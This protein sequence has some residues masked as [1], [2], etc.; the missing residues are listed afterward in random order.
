MP[1][2]SCGERGLLAAHVTAGPSFGGEHDAI[3]VAGALRRG[4][5]PPA[6]TRRSWDRVPASSGR[7]PIWVMAGSPRSTMP[8]RRWRSAAAR[9]WCRACLRATRASATAACL[10]TARRCSSCCSARC[11]CRCPRARTGRPA[12]TTRPS[13]PSISRAML[14]PGCPHDHGPHA[15]GGRAVLQGG[16]RGRRCT[17]KGDQWHLSA[18]AQRPCGEGRIAEVR[19]ERW[20]MEDGEEVEREVVGHPGAVG[21]VAHDGEQLYL[22]KQPREPVGD[23]GLLELPA[24]KLDD[25]CGGRARHRQARAGRGDRQGRAQ[26]AAPHNFLLVAGFLRRGNPR[27][28]GHRPLRRERGD[29]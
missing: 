9:L 19:L 20:R 4:L 3:T 22:V 23:P 26:L 24:G 8:T 17:G 13:S 21:I 16:A 5:R 18:W 15:G 10:T 6:G 2:G 27:V 11:S 12:D 14:A 28:P 1:C 29:R 7:A 25:D